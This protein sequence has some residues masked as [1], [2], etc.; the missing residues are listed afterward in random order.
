MQIFKKFARNCLKSAGFEIRRIQPAKSDKSPDIVVPAEK[1]YFEREEYGASNIETKLENVAKGQPFEYPDILNL[2]AAAVRLVGDA[3]RICELGCGTGN[4]ATG[5][6]DADPS[7]FIVASEFDAPTHEW[8]KQHK[9][10]SNIRYLLGPVPETEGPFDLV[11]AIEVIEHI[12][13]Y[14]NFIHV[15]KKLAP[16]ALLSTPNRARGAEYFHA[17]P[18]PYYKHVREWTAGEFYWVLR[19][20]Y[21]KITLYALTSQTEPQFITVNVD[22]QLS[23]LIA[24][25]T[26]PC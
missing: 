22:T 10:R 21:K 3:K 17:G 26:D 11:V 18:P 2:N 6:A 25:C 24:D 16:R 5:A 9:P 13:D 20:F 19:G 14:S 12:S 8:V 7:R 15:C 23:P 1:P 4:F